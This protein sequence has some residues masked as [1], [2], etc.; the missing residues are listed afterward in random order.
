MHPNG[1]GDPGSDS[2]LCQSGCGLCWRRISMVTRGVDS[3]TVCV[4]CT[5][6]AC[7]VGFASTTRHGAVMMTS[8]GCGCGC[9]CGCVHQP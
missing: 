4:L 7:T 8:I 3:S 5:L 6:S 9:G 1:P 2:A